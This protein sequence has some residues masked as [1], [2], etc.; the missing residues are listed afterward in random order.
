MHKILV[1]L[2]R[3]GS[4]FLLIIVGLLVALLVAMGVSALTQA[5]GGVAYM[6]SLQV[7]LIMALIAAVTLGGFLISLAFKT[8]TLEKEV[9][10]LETYDTLTG[11]LNRHEFI[12]RSA[13]LFN[14]AV[15]EKEALSIVIVSIDHFKNI[16]DVH[17]HVVGDQALIA[18]T[19]LLESTLRKSDLACRYSG[20]AFAFFLPK[21][22]EQ[23]GWVFCERI[24]Q[25]TKQK[26]LRYKDIA[27]R[28]T[29]SIGIVSFPEE[30]AETV[31]ALLQ[32]ADRALYHA[33]KTGRNRTVNYIEG[34]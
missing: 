9:N 11:L 7:A 34:I 20:E 17:G 27:I 8:D 23:Q 6:Q 25:I 18:F 29:L 30:R 32:L 1:E 2:G 5:N 12:D 19:K 22:D 15:R 13:Q 26:G 16:N 21:T 10:R 3:F 33:K 24:H 31:N 28:P 14:I 4:I